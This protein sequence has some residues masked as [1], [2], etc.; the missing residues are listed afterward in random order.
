MDQVDIK[1]GLNKQFIENREFVPEDQ[2]QNRQPKVA[3]LYYFYTNWC[4]YCKKARP[5]I[6][7]FKSEI[8]QNVFLLF[9]RR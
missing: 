5:V 3:T 9:F 4:P 2:D 8:V 6:N 7:E 1:P